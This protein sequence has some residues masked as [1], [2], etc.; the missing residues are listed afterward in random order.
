[1]WTDHNTTTIIFNEEF[2]QMIRNLKQLPEV[3]MLKDNMDLVEIGKIQD[4][5]RKQIP[6]KYIKQPRPDYYACMIQLLIN[7]EKCNTWEDVGLQ[8][9]QLS[10]VER[11]K[12]DITNE[13]GKLSTCMCGKMHVSN[14]HI[15]IHSDGKL[16]LME[17]CVCIDKRIINT[18][19]RDNWKMCKSRQR[20][21]INDYMKEIQT[22]WKLFSTKLF[23]SWIKPS[24][25]SLIHYKKEQKRIENEER[26]QRYMK[27]IEMHKQ[28]ISITKFKNIICNY[29]KYN[30]RLIKHVIKQLKN[31]KERDYRPYCKY[32]NMAYTG[33]GDVCI[34][35]D[36]ICWWI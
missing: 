26:I 21:I 25:Y 27:N 13:L 6:K 5:I 33:V 14:K 10:I 19:S 36:D 32:C 4:R 7:T 8:I 11:S 20:K 9:E 17:G 15:F 23:W 3:K 18:E 34:I 1:M 2:K 22:K 30:E 28:K 24:L 35:T 16:N 29:I 31:K 12:E